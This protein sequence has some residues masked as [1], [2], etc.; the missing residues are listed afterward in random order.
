MYRRFVDCFCLTS[1][2]GSINQMEM[3][4][5]NKIKQL[6]FFKRF[7]VKQVHLSTPMFGPPGAETEPVCSHRIFF[8]SLYSLF[9]DINACI[10]RF[11]QNKIFKAIR[12]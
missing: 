11:R 6:F 10:L 8:V 9:F 2:I 7:F 4:K 1:L 5:N 3:G 12:F